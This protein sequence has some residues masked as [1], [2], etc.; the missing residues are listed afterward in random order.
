M[1]ISTLVLTFDL[2]TAVPYTITL[3]KSVKGCPKII[4]DAW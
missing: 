3:T 1:Y 2:N 4:L